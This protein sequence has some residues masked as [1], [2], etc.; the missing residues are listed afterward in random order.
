MDVHIHMV[1]DA[2]LERTVSGQE[3]IRVSKV[4]VEKG[5]EEHVYMCWNLDPY[6][7]VILLRG[8]YHSKFDMILAMVHQSEGLL[9]SHDQD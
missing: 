7:A 8:V 3:W 1:P 6:S 2:V 9:Q 5:F 4:G